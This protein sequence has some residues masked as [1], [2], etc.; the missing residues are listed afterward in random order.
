MGKGGGASVDRLASARQ[1]V[2]RQHTLGFSDP[3][4]SLETILTRF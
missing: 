2:L 3:S 4:T 1:R